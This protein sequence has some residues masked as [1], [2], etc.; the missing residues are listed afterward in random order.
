MK[1][2]GSGFRPGQWVRLAE[3]VTITRLVDGELE[4]KVIPAGTVGIHYPLDAGPGPQKDRTYQR[5]DHGPIVR[6]GRPEKGSQIIREHAIA[7]GIH[8]A[9][10]IVTPARAAALAPA[11]AVVVCGF[12][13]VDATGFQT[14]RDVALSPAQLVPVTDRALIPAPRLAT[15]DA[16]WTPEA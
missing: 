16:G 2:L 10:D 13:Q 6:K 12:H 15:M 1:R 3:D 4:E 14:V 5:A 7:H 9:D 11:L 8:K